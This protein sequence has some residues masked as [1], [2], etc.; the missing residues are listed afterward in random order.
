MGYRF[1]PFT[2]NFDFCDNNFRGILSSAP[3]NPREGWFYI[4]DGDNK[5]YVYYGEQWQELHALVAPTYATIVTGN[6]IGLLLGLTYT[7]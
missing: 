7:V 3:N 5:L 2:A 4:N 1:N 6:P